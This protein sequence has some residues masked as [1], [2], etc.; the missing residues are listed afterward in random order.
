MNCHEQAEA[1]STSVARPILINRITREG[2]YNEVVTKMVASGRINRSVRDVLVS[3]AG[4]CSGANRGCLPALPRDG[5]DRAR[6]FSPILG[7]ARRADAAGLSDLAGAAGALGDRRQDL[8]GAILRAGGVRVA[9]RIWRAL[10]RAPPTSG[11][12]DIQREVSRRSAR[13]AA[14][15]RS[16]RGLLSR[17]G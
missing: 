14:E 5:P 10:R 7:N 2:S 1:T 9:P 15:Q 4:A 6:A 3:V 17:H 16:V 12:A 8:H 11:C 13:A